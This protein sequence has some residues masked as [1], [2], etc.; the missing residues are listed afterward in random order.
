MGLQAYSPLPNQVTG[1]EQT[2]GRNNYSQGPEIGLSRHGA[3]PRARREPQRVMESQE[4]LRESQRATGMT[5]QNW[6]AGKDSRRVLSQGGAMSESWGSHE[7]S[8]ESRSRE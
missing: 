4:G 2:T 7:G 6:R 1:L 3:E 5:Q 8:A